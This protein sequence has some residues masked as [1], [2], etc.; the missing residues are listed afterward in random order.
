MTP[1]EWC[2]KYVNQPETVSNSYHAAWMAFLPFFL[3]NQYLPAENA[4]KRLFAKMVADMD[5]SAQEAVHLCSET[6]SSAVVGRL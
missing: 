4:A 5:I 2:S 3:K 1:M 6:N